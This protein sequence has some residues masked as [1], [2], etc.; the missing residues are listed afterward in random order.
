MERE[1][2]FK[3]GVK[4]KNGLNNCEEITIVKIKIENILLILL[5]SYEYI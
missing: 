2:N 4:M 3:H 5:I 1:Y